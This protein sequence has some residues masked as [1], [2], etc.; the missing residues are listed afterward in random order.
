V[1]LVA[2]GTNGFYPARGR[3]TMSFLVCDG[4]RALLLD[5]GSGVARLG[6][7]PVRELL[8]GVPRL[9]IVLTHYHLDHV[10]GLSY[11]PGVWR[12]RSV[13]VWGPAPP[14]VDGD[15]SAL[16]RLLAP[17]FFPRLG[18]WPLAI[19]VHAYAA[20]ADLAELGWDLTVRR[21]DHPGGSVGLRLGAS[22]AYTTDTVGD[23]A[24]A[25]FVAGV[26]LLLHELWW[27]DDELA[28][29]ASPGGHSAM[30]AVAEIARQAG[31]GRLAPVHHRPD[32]DLGAIANLA[33]ELA[34]RSGVEVE[35]LVEGQ[36]VE[37]DAGQARGRL[38]EG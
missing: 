20:S 12:G 7:E 24:T 16:D 15:P 21:Q 26:G 13:R 11:L 38:G 23:L 29:A 34:A 35:L 22:L 36:I 4:A 5:A 18:D 14:L 17:P 33:T 6:E 9:D 28:A 27:T 37:L 30:T 19:S 8:A 2:L 32:R 1:K 10:V 31:V 25:E 3:A